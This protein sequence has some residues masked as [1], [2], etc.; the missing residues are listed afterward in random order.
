MIFIWIAG[1]NDND[2]EIEKTLAILIGIVAVAALIIVFISFWG[3]ASEAAKGIPPLSLSFY[4][5]FSTNFLSSCLCLNNKL[6]MHKPISTDMRS[7]KWIICPII[8]VFFGQHLSNSINTYFLGTTT[9]FPEFS[10]LHCRWQISPNYMLWLWTY[11][12]KLC[13]FN[14]LWYRILLNVVLVRGL[15]ASFFPLSI[16]I[17]LWSFFAGSC[18]EDA[19]G[20]TKRCSFVFL[21]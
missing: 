6:I 3:K 9:Y 16:R 8:Y 17:L 14:T 13:F 1:S 5:P 18:K 7:S 20:Q 2:D 10:V 21:C 19:K 12:Q 11:Q 15:M 4:I